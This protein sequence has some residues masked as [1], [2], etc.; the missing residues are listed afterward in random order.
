MSKADIP[1][2]VEGWNRAFAFDRADAQRFEDVVFG[3][4]NSQEH[5]TLVAEELGRIVGFASCAA[6]EGTVGADG[7]GTEKDI[8]NGYLKGLFYQ[9]E[10]AGEALL[11]ET[12]GFLHSRG[13]TT[14]RVV[15]YTGR[16]FF[17]GIDLRYESLLGFLKRNGFEETSRIKDVSLDLL[18]YQPGGQEYQRRQWAR[19][20]SAGVR[21]VSYRREMLAQMRAFVEDLN[22]PI[23]FG[24]E[25]EKDWRGR[26]TAVVAVKGDRIVG[27][28]CWWPASGASGIGGLGP[29]ATLEAERGKGIGSCMLDECMRRSKQAGVK[30][31][32]A[33]WANTPFYLKNGWRICREYAALQKRMQAPSGGLRRLPDCVP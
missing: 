13:K 11:E 3:D 32:V 24:R 14:I 19:A 16:Y 30:T 25:W 1:E 28:A 29:I 8:D 6:R 10:P 31:V 4:P 2:V 21:I 15:Q 12:G 23:W 5:G 20:R 26:E 27:F 9:N 22:I 18:S 7:T 17:P 33:G